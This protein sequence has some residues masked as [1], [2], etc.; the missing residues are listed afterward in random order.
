MS[1]NA[2]FLYVS[3]AARIFNPLLKFAVTEDASIK[4]YDISAWNVRG[5]QHLIPHIFSVLLPLALQISFINAAL[6]LIRTFVKMCCHPHSGS[7]QYI[8]TLQNIFTNVYQ[9]S[10]SL[11]VSQSVFYNKFIIP[12]II[13]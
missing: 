6:L 5:E 2:V 8:H 12:C 9:L 10:L 13:S 1:T 11:V 7:N 4:R 3:T